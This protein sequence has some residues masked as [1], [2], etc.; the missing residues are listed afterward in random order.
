MKEREEH[1]HHESHPDVD[2]RLARIAGHIE[3]IRRMIG[4]EKP[5]PQIL[6]QMKA[7]ISALESA[8]RIILTDHVQHCLAHAIQKKNSKD[9][10]DEIKQ[11]LSQIL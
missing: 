10:V 4:E 2:K 6:Q 7:V 3:G 9:A 1:H 5:C 8:R 11:I